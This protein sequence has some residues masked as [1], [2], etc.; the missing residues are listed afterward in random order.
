MNQFIKKFQNPILIG[1]YLAPNPDVYETF[2][3]LS[4]KYIP[5][6]LEK[7]FNGCFV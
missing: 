2:H 5:F 4:S 3:T 6:E 1:K 7:A